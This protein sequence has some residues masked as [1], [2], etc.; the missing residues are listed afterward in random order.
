MRQIYATNICKIMTHMCDFNVTHVCLKSNVCMY[1]T[2]ACVSHMFVAYVC[3]I[4]LSHMFVTYVCHICLSVQIR[5][6]YETKSRMC[7]TYATNICVKH[8]RQTYAT[9]ICKIMTHMCDLHVTHVCLKNNVC[10]YKTDACVSHMFVAYVCH[11]CLSHMFV[12]FTH[13]CAC[14]RAYVP[15]KRAYVLFSGWSMVFVSRNLQPL[16]QEYTQQGRQL[17]LM[18]C[19][20]SSLAKELDTRFWCCKPCRQRP[21]ISSLT[22][23][24]HHKVCFDRLCAS[25]SRIVCP[26]RTA[27]RR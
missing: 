18:N 1:K 22:R 5:R 14:V 2:D 12:F 3:R 17:S 16:F 8:M 10:M 27:G 11:I 26:P 24:C 4:C 13:I 9:N 15:V 20:C 23:V 6:T 21:R 19:L 25:T 7:Q